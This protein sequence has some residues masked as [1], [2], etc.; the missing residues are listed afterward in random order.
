YAKMGYDTAVFTERMENQIRALR[1]QSLAAV[2]EIDPSLTAAQASRIIKL[3]PL[4]GAAQI[5]E[6]TAVA[7]S[8]TEVLAQK[9]AATRAA[10][11]Y[12]IFRELCDPARIAV[13]FRK[14]EAFTAEALAGGDNPLEQLGGLAAGNPLELLNGLTDS[15]NPE[16]T[17]PPDPYLLWLIAPSPDGQYAAVE[18]AEADTATFVYRTG[19][20]FDRFAKK[21]NRALEAVSFRREV[22]RLSDEEL[23]K[24]ENADYYMAAKR[25]PALQFVRANFAGRIIHSSADSWKRKLLDIWSG[26]TAAENRNP[27]EPAHSAQ[28]FCGQCGAARIADMKFCGNCGAKV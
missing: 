14:N 20:D 22:I 13:G 3:M 4:G 19:G 23:R 27:P 6:L 2:K 28:R 7:P 15:A 26:Q 1:E 25:T 5:G 18:F 8:F 12:Q 16:E 24:P 21:L 10:E 11:S 9:L 17:A